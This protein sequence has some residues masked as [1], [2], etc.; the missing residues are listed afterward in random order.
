MA[1]KALREWVVIVA[2]YVANVIKAGAD[3]LI[4]ASP[5][6]ELGAR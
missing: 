2:A 4:Q 3:R 6:V 5:I 1:T